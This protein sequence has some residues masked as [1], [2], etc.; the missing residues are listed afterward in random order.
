MNEFKPKLRKSKKLKDKLE[1]KNGLL[2]DTSWRAVVIIL[3]ILTAS[4]IIIA[5]ALEK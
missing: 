2:L 3:G 1:R 4:T 5:S